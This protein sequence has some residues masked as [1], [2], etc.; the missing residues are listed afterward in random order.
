MTPAHK[1]H[2]FQGF[3]A[4]ILISNSPTISRSRSSLI[5]MNMPKEIMDGKD[6]VVIGDS[7]DITTHFPQNINPSGRLTLKA[8]RKS[9]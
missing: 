2:N 7:L 5:R 1:D 6:R 8:K 4:F 3:Q 9:T